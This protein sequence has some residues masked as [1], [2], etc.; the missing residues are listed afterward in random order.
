VRLMGQPKRL[1]SRI[2]GSTSRNDA[3]RLHYAIPFGNIDTTCT[4]QVQTGGRK[5]SRASAPK[6]PFFNGQNGI[7]TGQFVELQSCRSSM[8]TAGQLDRPKI[9]TG[10]AMTKY[11]VAT[12]RPDNYAPSVDFTTAGSTQDCDR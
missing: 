7:N 6:R 4:M 3:H 2:F 10:E 8:S 5:V 1:G 11:S 12:H 9:V